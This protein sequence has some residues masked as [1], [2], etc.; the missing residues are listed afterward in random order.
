MALLQ[1]VDFRGVLGKIK[2]KLGYSKETSP[3][4][5]S[6]RGGV[7]TGS[8]GALPKCTTR[9]VVLARRPKTCWSHPSP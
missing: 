7:Q 4:P 3:L 6:R 5:P 9:E 2:C 8:R 1:V